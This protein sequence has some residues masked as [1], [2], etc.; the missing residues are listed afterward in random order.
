MFGNQQND[1]IRIVKASTGEISTEIKARVDSRNNIIYI[2]FQHLPVNWHVEDGD[3]LQ[4]ELPGN[5]IEKFTIKNNGYQPAGR[6][7]P[8]RYE[9]VVTKGDTFDREAYSSI[10]YNLH[11]DNSR[12][13]NNSVD[14]SSNV[15][16]SDQGA[17][18]F[19]L[20]NKIIEE[21]LSSNSKL[22]DLVKDMEQS[23]KDK[24][25]ISLETYQKFIAQ[26]ANHMTLFSPFIPALTEMLK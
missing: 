25:F 19:I 15:I 2:Y 4:R 22:L 11:G 3:Y 24:S 5:K 1:K 21:Q 26:A 18:V 8:E 9:C 6:I 17:E 16:S 13:Y 12:V 20:L 10:T 23:K 7:S 14:N